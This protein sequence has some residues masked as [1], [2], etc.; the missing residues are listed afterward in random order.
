MKTCTIYG[1][2]SSDSA[3]DNYPTVQICD[4]CVEADDKRQEDAQIVSSGE[5]DPSFGES[6]EFCD[7][8]YEEE[9]QEKL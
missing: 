6:C 3:A 1:D 2:L 7:K 9:R 5:Y 8:M 4:E